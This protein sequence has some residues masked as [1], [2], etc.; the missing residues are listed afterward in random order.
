MVDTDKLHLADILRAAQHVRRFVRD[1]DRK[2]FPQELV[3]RRAVVGRIIQMSGSTKRLSSQF[4]ARHAE[5]PWDAISAIGDRLVRDGENVH[6][7]EIWDFSR[8]F[9]PQLILRIAALVPAEDR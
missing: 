8:S 3:R 1:T 5:V 2:R 4:R 9:V 7:E 6:P